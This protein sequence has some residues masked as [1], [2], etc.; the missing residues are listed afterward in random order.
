[1]H[2]DRLIS[3]AK[4]LLL[5][6]CTYAIVGCSVTGPEYNPEWPQDVT[7]QSS[8][9]FFP[10]DSVD[11]LSPGNW[12]KAHLDSLNTQISLSSDFLPNEIVED[13][14]TSAFNDQLIGNSLPIRID[15]LRC[16]NTY[17]GLFTSTVNNSLDSTELAIANS[18]AIDLIK[19]NLASKCG[20]AIFPTF[21]KPGII[22]G[23]IERESYYSIVGTTTCSLLIPELLDEQQNSNVEGQ[24]SDLQ[25][26]TNLLRITRKYGGNDCFFMHPNNVSIDDGGGFKL[27]TI[28]PTLSETGGGTTDND[29]DD[30]YQD[31]WEA[32]YCSIDFTQHRNTNIPRSTLRLNH[33][34]VHGDNLDA[35]ICHRI[36]TFDPAGPNIECGNWGGTDHGPYYTPSLIKA[37]TTNNSWVP[38]LEVRF[39]EGDNTLQSYIVS[40]Y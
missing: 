12:A 2:L 25:N 40:Y 17:C 30:D 3:Q 37:T 28:T 20:L 34:K 8:E 7:T 18:K 6:S 39:S 21:G 32:V 19:V 27:I 13:S 23:V 33:V 15:S 22:S 29:D 31:R 24:P 11:G 26:R 16:N 14:L 1:M 9:D 36:Q 5:I 38:V 4:I 35:Q 10:S